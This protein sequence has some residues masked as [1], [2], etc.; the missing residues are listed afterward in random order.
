ML[1]MEIRPKVIN[2]VTEKI[3]A[4]RHKAEHKMYNNI[5]VLHTNTMKT[6]TNYF[7]KEQLS[8]LYF[9]FPDPHFK[10]QNFR[11]R[12]INENILSEYAFVL[13]EGGMIY[14]VT[15]VKDLFDWNVRMLES[16][17]MFQR[18]PNE[19][20]EGDEYVDAMVN[21]TDESKKVTR[22]GGNKYWAVYK[23]VTQF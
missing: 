22:K 15:D 14:T 12:I 17:P 1:G 10:K 23:K 3:R 19:Q 20:L 11:R 7:R 16:H 4:L 21:H 9:C 6:L 18:V 5:A 8:K 13:K 2:F